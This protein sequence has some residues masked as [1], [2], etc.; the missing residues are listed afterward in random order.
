VQTVDS[1]VKEASTLLQKQV[2]SVSEVSK[3]AADIASV[4]EENAAATE[5]CA[6]STEEESAS[7]QEITNAIHDLNSLGKSLE[8]TL[9]KFTLPGAPKDNTIPEPSKIIEKTD[10]MLRKQSASAS[11]LKG[12]QVE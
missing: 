6:A 3:R 2:N 7:M 10:A 5:E 12:A 9:S 1:T 8:A 11:R 4:A